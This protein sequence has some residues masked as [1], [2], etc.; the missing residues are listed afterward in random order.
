MKIGKGMWPLSSDIQT[1]RR[2]D[3]IPNAC[4][5]ENLGS[6]DQLIRKGKH[7][8]RTVMH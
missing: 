8:H 2:S 6:L 3:E 5:N 1:D 7:Y 4:Q